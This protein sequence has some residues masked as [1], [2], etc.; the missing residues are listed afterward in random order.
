MPGGIGRLEGTP[1]TGCLEVGFA[2][3][4]EVNHVYTSYIFV[5]CNQ[6]VYET[7]LAKYGA[8]RLSTIHIVLVHWVWLISN[9]LEFGLRKH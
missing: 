1:A 9:N 2:Y 6:Y 4:D 5:F 8:R 3:F 7:N